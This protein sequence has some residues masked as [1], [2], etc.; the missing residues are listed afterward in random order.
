MSR[1]FPGLRASTSTFHAQS[2]SR[3]ALPAVR[4]YATQVRNPLA[5]A[6]PGVKTAEDQ[7]AS[8]K[9]QMKAMEKNVGS[10]DFS[11]MQV[12]IIGAYL[13]SLVLPLMRVT[14]VSEELALWFA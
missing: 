3:S 10:M 4:Q 7:I 5:G 6:A 2:S 8:Q 9:K 11:S 12:G 14:S 1:L 13:S